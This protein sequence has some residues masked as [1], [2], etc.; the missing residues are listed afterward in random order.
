MMMNKASLKA[1]GATTRGGTW[2][3]GVIYARAEPLARRSGTNETMGAGARGEKG[4][5][6]VEGLPAPPSL[7]FSPPARL[8][9]LSLPPRAPI[10]LGINCA[11]SS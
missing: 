1:S 8:L 3:R 2:K 6:S 11:R 10:A 7:S 4:E 9:A 5:G